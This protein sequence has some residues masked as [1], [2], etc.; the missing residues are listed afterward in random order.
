MSSSLDVQVALSR[1]NVPMSVYLEEPLYAVLD[2]S[3][4]ASNTAGSSRA[5]LN[6]AL[7]VDSSATMHHFQLT[8]DERDYWLGLAISR[9]E[10]ERGQADD[11]EAIYWTGQTLAEMQAVARKP[12][13]LAVEAIK[14]L[15]AT[16]QPTDRVSVIA[17]ADRVHPV[18]TAQDWANYPEQCL[19]QM[20]LL[21]EQ[22]LPVDIG[23]GTYMAEALR[24]GADA[25]KQ[26]A[27]G[28]VN[29]LIVISDGIV[30]DADVTL[31]N[32]T[33]IQEEGFAITTLGVGDDFD[34]EFLTKIADNSR[35]QYYYAADVAEITDHLQQEMTTLETIT[36]TDLY[37]AVR[38]LGG[39]MVQ[40][41]FQVR[42][43]MA[44]FDELYTEDDWLR[45]RIGDVSSEAPVSVL[46]QIAPAQMS[47]GTQPIAEAQFTW[48]QPT[49]VGAG[50]QKVTLTAN[51]TDDAG[52]LA[53][54]NSE[55]GNLVDRFSIYKFEREAQRAQERGDLER[56]KEKLGAATRELHKIGEESLA[57]DMEQQIA[58]LGQSAAD[59]TRIKRIKAT[60][61]RL[62]NTPT[63]ANTPSNT[64]E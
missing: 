46:L 11:R 54:T 39:S 47:A 19:L 44:V 15:L 8:D 41:V 16:L 45:T 57:Q 49:G 23:T 50:T 40:D 36:I 27:T 20:D 25:L 64:Q 5:P 31:L 18:F 59:P 58:A 51:V 2:L 13:A 55:V 4:S 34:E 38:G 56:A 60:T 10:M 26:N 32:V 37:I 63:E 35:G 12:M 42:P 48:G 14:N 1:P 29:R 24:A 43:A 22:R 62:A 7:V 30:Q 17:F 53:Q 21:R 52:L 33:A 28:G 3:P 9:D 61:R 6:I